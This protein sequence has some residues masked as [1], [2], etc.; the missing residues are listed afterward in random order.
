MRTL[1]DKTSIN[2]VQLKNRFIRSAT[3]EHLADE[4]GFLTDRISNLYE[5][6]A[7]GGVG[8]IITSLAYITENSK[9]TNGQ[10]GL[11]SD[12]L[13]QEYEKLTSTIHKYGSKIFVQL[14]FVTL[15]GEF[16]TPMNVTADDIQS[17]VTAFGD[18]AARAK[19][20]GFDGIQIHAAHGFLFSQ[21]LSP[22]F[23]KRIDEY[24]GSIDNR[25]RI[26]FDSYKAI[27]DKVGPDYPV[28]IKINSEDF[29]N[30]GLSFDECKQVC[31]KLEE[32]GMDAIEISGG[33]LISPPNLGTS[34]KISKNEEAYFKK[35]AEEI[36]KDINVPVILVGGNRDFESISNIL[37]QT[38]IE[39]FSLARPL[40]CESN[41]INRWKEGDFKPAKCLSCN[42]CLE[43]TEDVTRC[44]FNR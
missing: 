20:A 9:A 27:R 23:N 35:Y 14:A 15:N 24:N 44:V 33:T 40:L 37:N 12:E 5:D 11:Y 32:I 28:I 42:K 1:F 21:F 18:A 26:I 39:Y 13:I 22:Y 7:K 30:E 43:S 6:L 17:I 2:K 31:T 34:R 10:I 4:A 25:A 36:A 29:I 41:L 3:T 19:K 8:L 38:D 16:L